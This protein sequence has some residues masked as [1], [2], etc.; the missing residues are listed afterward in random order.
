[1]NQQTNIIESLGN[2]GVHVTET[3]T[4]PSRRGKKPRP[5]WVVSGNTFGLDNFFYGIGGKKYRG[6]WSFFSDPSEE[7]LQELNSNGRQGFAEQLEGIIERKTARIEKFEGY[8]EN[9]S[10]RSESAYK[11]ANSV[12]SMIPMGQPVLVGHHSEGRH[13]RDLRR[14]DSGMRKSIE[15]SKKSEYYS[16]KANSLGHQVNQMANN[17][18]YIANRIR[19]GRAELARLGRQ[20]HLTD[21]PLAQAQLQTRISNALE[22]LTVWQEKLRALEDEAVAKGEQV[23]SPENLKA[24]DLVYYRGTWYPVVRVNQ[25]SVTIGNWLGVATFTFKVEYAGITKF[26]CPE[27]K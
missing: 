22:R 12:A 7:I 27:K 13:R 18:T 9:A 1:M 10:A 2:L 17:R 5:V 24:G 6:A 21:E 11:K 20:N 23:A 15:E 25:K 4:T 26:R 3:M 14:I 19:E 8:S 16:D